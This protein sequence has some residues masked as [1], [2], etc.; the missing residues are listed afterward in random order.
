M[1]RKCSSNIS[2]TR[3]QRVS[4]CSPHFFYSH[5]DQTTTYWLV[6]AVYCTRHC[7]HLLEAAVIQRL[8]NL[9]R[10]D[11]DEWETVSSR[12]IAGPVQGKK[13]SKIGLKLEDEQDISTSA[14]RLFY[15]RALQYPP[16]FCMFVCFYLFWYIH[17]EIWGLNKACSQW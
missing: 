2:L 8:H 10:E 6:Q 1:N 13:C 4:Q 16:G 5:Y 9:N 14:F 11:R 3:W 17:K 12:E 15:H 7:V